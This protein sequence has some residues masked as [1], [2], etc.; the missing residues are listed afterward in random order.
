MDVIPGWSILKWRVPGHRCLF[1]CD[2]TRGDHQVEHICLA[3]PGCVR[4]DERVIPGRSLGQTRQQ[5]RFRQIEV[6]CR[7]AE[8]GLCRRLNP[9]SD[10]AIVDLIEIKLQNGVFGITAGDLGGQ[11]GLF[12][13]PTECAL[14]PFLRRQ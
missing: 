2:V 13:L 1:R 6:G 14:A 4:I 8:I 7:L 5:G 9:I 10:V 11:N 3:P 12:D